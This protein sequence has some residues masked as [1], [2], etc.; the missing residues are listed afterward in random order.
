MGR[1]PQR[2]GAVVHRGVYGGGKQ[3]IQAYTMVSELEPPYAKMAELAKEAGQDTVEV[4]NS[5]ASHFGM[6][7]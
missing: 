2:K 1:F 7:D 4:R 5:L 3:G 6:A